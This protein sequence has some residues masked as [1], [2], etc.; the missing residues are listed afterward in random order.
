MRLVPF[1]RIFGPDERDPA[2]LDKLK[3]EA[4]HI[5]AW[6]IAGCIE[7]QRRGLADVPTVVAAQTKEYREEQDL[8]GQ[9]LEER[10]D[11]DSAARECRCPSKLLYQDYCEWAD[12]NGLRPCSA[13]ALGRRLRERGFVSERKASGPEFQGIALKPKH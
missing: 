1:S 5:L 7:W 13:I 8:V 9:W 4:P 6:M 11:S 12:A 3:A 2:L 10:V